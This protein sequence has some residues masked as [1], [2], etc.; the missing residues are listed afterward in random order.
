MLHSA[1]RKRGA[2]AGV[3]ARADQPS[4]AHAPRRRA[5]A[6]RA[7]RIALCIACFWIVALRAEAPPTTAAT[8]VG[9][10]SAPT[11][12][13]D[14]LPP[15]AMSSDAYA[16]ERLRRIRLDF[17]HD[18]AEIERRLRAEIPGLTTAELDAWDAAG[19][20]ECLLID[21]ERRYFAR[22]ASNLFRLSPEAL[23]RRDPKHG[24][25]SEGPLERLHPH[26]AEVRAASRASGNTSVAPRRVRIT[27]SL[28]VK[29]DAVPAGETIRAWIP[30]PR[31]IAGQ[32][33]GIR[34][35]ASD[36]KRHRLA[37][38]SALQRTVYFERDARAGEPTRFEIVY[39]LTIHARAHA[40][41]AAEVTAMPNDPALAPY[42]AERPPHV[43]FSDALKRYS[44]HAVGD[45]RTPYE[46]TR[47]LFDAVDRV[48]WAGAREYS[49]I[50]NIPEYVMRTGHG[51]C[52]QQTLL[53]IA[54]LRLNGIPARWQ[55]GWVYSDGDYTNLHDWGQVY[56]APRGWVPIDVTTGRLAGAD[57]SLAYFYLGG[58]DAY[59]IAMNDDWA[60]DFVP[61][62]HHFRS[63]D[64][65]SQRGEAE[66][67]GGNLYYDQFDYAFEAKLLP[68]NR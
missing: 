10:A 44:Q 50:A 31:A 43:V 29:A 49:T 4:V 24:P 26:H 2:T 23:A 38:E 52:G 65:D 1:H 64:V 13:C 40:I 45:A 15:H 61:A 39:E 42:L 32:Q 9:G 54:L 60:R 33:S 5:A 35:L 53:L 36:P 37:P 22:A 55:S 12:A 66:W 46:I 68:T 7:A 3:D 20:L 58:L 19:L 8:P 16:R 28:T 17:P 34:T 14:P 57:A 48:P 47:R 25:P 62:K 27:Q 51:D 41:D 6:P 30:Y 63:D 11:A 18:R 21:G 59:R 56:L 67:D